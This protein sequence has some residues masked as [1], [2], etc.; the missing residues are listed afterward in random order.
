[1]SD[2]VV[3]VTDEQAKAIQEALKTLQASGGFLRSTFGTM[4]EDVDRD[5]GR[6]PFEGAYPRREHRAHGRQGEK[7]GERIGNINNADAPPSLAIPIMIAAGDESRD[8]LQDLRRHLRPPQPIQAETR[9]FASRS[10]RS[11]NKWTLSTRE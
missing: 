2:G 10:S 4:P 8:E 3:P 5:V 9:A 1:M 7:A 11:S 6:R